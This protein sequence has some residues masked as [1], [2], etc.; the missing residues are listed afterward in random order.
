M[1]EIS[2]SKLEEQL[3]SG[4]NWFYWI[5]VLSLVNSVIILSGSDRYFIIGLAT[6]LMTDLVIN[7]WFALVFDV[8]VAGVLIAFG[9]FAKKGKSGIFVV[10]MTLYGLD[11]ML[12][13]AF[14]DYLSF[15]FH[16]LALY[17]IYRGLNASMKL[18]KFDYRVG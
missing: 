18:K 10:G 4:A 9:I 17:G 16:L 13:I 14:D 1:G 7:S 3:N 12:Y 15:A 11:A 8:I 5:A 6:T 2:I